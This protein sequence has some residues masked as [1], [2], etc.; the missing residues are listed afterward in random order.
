VE[1][2]GF[3]SNL[4]SYLGFRELKETEKHDYKLWCIQCENTLS[5]VI[6]FVILNYMKTDLSGYDCTKAQGIGYMYSSMHF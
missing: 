2:W 3:L 5:G 6:F 4:C 1:R